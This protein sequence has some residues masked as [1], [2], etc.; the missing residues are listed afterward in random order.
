[1]K[2]HAKTIQGLSLLILGVSFLVA[3]SN[4]QDEARPFADK[5]APQNPVMSQWLLRTKVIDSAGCPECVAAFNACTAVPEKK[6]TGEV[7]AASDDFKAG[8]I[9]RE[10]MTQTFET[11]KATYMKASSACGATFEKC[12]LDEMRKAKAASKAKS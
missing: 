11:A 5:V 12:C 3:Y 2:K 9:K 8:K 4:N 6:F 7:G 10:E 1:M